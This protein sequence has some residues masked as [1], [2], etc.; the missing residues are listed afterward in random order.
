MEEQ[1]GLTNFL[2]RGGEGTVQNFWKIAD[3][4]NTVHENSSSDGWQK[5]SVT[6]EPIW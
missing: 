1:R 4:A 5:H 6:S 3:E 2:Q